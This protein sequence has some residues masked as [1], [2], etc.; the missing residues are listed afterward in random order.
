[1]FFK[2]KTHLACLSYAGGH[3]IAKR[4]QLVAGAGDDFRNVRN[5]VE[6]LSHYTRMRQAASLPHENGEFFSL[7]INHLL[8]CSKLYNLLKLYFRLRDK[9]YH[10]SLNAYLLF[11]SN[12][13][14]YT[15]RS[16]IISFSIPNH[17]RCV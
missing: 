15:Y 13:C 14:V 1:M 16:K 12:Y 10:N 11:K 3:P 2:G 17:T 4:R 6:L 7:K 8:S 5:D 9:I